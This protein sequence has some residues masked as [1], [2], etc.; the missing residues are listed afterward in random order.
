MLGNE[1]RSLSVEELWYYTNIVTNE[2][3]L[4]NTYIIIADRS[5]IEKASG[6]IDQLNPAEPPLSYYRAGKLKIYPE[7]FTLSI[8]RYL[9]DFM[10]RSVGGGK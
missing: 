7:T 2:E 9:P 3:K 6:G 5:I 4:N 8:I 10:L 1:N